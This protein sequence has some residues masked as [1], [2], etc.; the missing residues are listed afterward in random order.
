MK[1]YERPS[2]KKLNTS[3]TAIY[4]S[5]NTSMEDRDAILHTAT[6]SESQR[7][8]TYLGLPALVGKS[9][10]KEFNSIIDQIEKRLQD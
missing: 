3:K 1:I 9:H 6:I 7:Y 5:R 4:F 2:G 10:V 8:N